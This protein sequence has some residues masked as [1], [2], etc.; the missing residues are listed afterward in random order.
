MLNLQYIPTQK[1]K[2]KSLL[3]DGLENYVF[4]MIKC[5]GLERWDIIPTGHV[6]LLIWTPND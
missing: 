1:P 2:I 5:W 3:K 4:F 6:I